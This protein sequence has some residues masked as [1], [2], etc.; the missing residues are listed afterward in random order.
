VSKTQTKFNPPRF[1]LDFLIQWQILSLRL[2]MYTSNTNY[3][4]ISAL[5]ALKLFIFLTET[6]IMLYS[7]T[8]EWSSSTL[9]AF[10]KDP[11][12]QRE[13]K[14]IRNGFL[15]H[16]LL[17]NLCPYRWQPLSP[18]LASFIQ[19]SFHYIHINFTP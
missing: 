10:R 19:C 5:L 17:D 15:C 1:C 9:E 8:F 6:Q 12:R 2:A 11:E 4:P 16:S 14:I 18:A 3:R 7:L 13:E